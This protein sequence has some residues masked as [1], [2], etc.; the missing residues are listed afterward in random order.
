VPP[1]IEP[2]AMYGDSQNW[3]SRKASAHQL[4]GSFAELSGTEEETDGDAAARKTATRSCSWDKLTE[5]AL[6][7]TAPYDPFA[8]C[9][10]P[11]PFEFRSWPR[12]SLA[13]LRAARCRGPRDLIGA[14]A[15]HT[16]LDWLSLI[17]WRRCPGSLPP[18]S[19]TGAPDIRNSGS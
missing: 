18:V 2:A 13:D 3:Q 14:H 17:R 8:N 6:C 4:W 7:D 16:D 1:K 5:T 10:L 12:A 9:E 11:H 19:T 15:A